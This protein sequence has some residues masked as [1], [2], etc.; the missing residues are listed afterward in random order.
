M[1]L[2][3]GYYGLHATVRN[4]SSLTLLRMIQIS[5]GICS[6]YVQVRHLSVNNYGKYMFVLSLIGFASITAMPGVNNSVMQAVSRGHE[7][8]FKEA[9]AT[10]VLGSI[11]GALLLAFGGFYIY[12]DDANMGNALW[13]S[14]ILFTAANGLTQWKSYFMGKERFMDILVW[15]GLTTLVINAL[16]IYFSLNQGDR[17][18]LQ[19]MG[20]MGPSALVNICITLYVIGMVKRHESVEV[21]NIRYGLLTSFYAG[22][23]SILPN[24]DRTIVYTF[25]SSSGLAMYVTASRVPELFAGLMQDV[26]AAVAPNLSRQDG[27]TKSLNK[28]MRQITLICAIGGLILIFFSKNLI[29]LIYGNNFLGAVVYMQILIALT[30][31][32]S[33]ANLK[34][35]YIRSQLDVSGFR[36]VTL[37]SSAI[38]LIA[39][40][41]LVPLLNIWGVIMAICIYSISFRRLV[42]ERL[43]AHAKL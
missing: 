33:S 17:I 31:A 14:S 19:I 41:V 4:I 27:Y 3:K 42:S 5:L 15:D 25:C 26:S 28:K 29:L 6:T 34:F 35:R 39:L 8:T 16:L 1:K 12:R 30:V 2:I 40:L 43:M 22:L 11:I 18:D 20:Y 7:G 10:C 21:G 13:M 32:N 9:L 37:A 23:G 24:L 36:V 38:R